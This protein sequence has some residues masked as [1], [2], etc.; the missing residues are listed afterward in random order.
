MWE[1]PEPQ[2]NQP[3]YFLNATPTQ[4]EAIPLK[5]GKLSLPALVQKNPKTDKRIGTTEPWEGLVE[6]GIDPKDP[7]PQEP[8]GFFH[9]LALPYPWVWVLGFSLLACLEIGGGLF[10]L[11]RWWQQRRAARLARKQAAIALP[12]LSPQEEALQALQKLEALGWLQQGKEKPFAFRLSEILRVYLG[13]VYH[14]EALERTTEEVLRELKKRKEWNPSK[15]L[16]LQALLDGLDWI[17][18][19]DGGEAASSNAGQLLGLI[20]EWIQKG[21]DHATG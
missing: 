4:F 1:F 6:T 19:T 2:E 9:P 17:K 16:A 21:E 14:F 11:S 12:P 7:R 13:R 3:W 18:F 5:A 15:R 20:R 8:E 10:L